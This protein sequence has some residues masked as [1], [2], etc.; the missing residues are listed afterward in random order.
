MR[1]TLK[2]TQEILRRKVPMQ[3]MSVGMENHNDC[4]QRTG[5]AEKSEKGLEGE[6]PNNE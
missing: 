4:S 6:G 1:P 3:E 5:K 2:H